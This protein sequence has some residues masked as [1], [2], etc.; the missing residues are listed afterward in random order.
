MYSILNMFPKFTIIYCLVAAIFATAV[1]AEST[2]TMPL[3]ASNETSNPGATKGLITMTVPPEA[4][5]SSSSVDTTT[6]PAEDTEVSKPNLVPKTGTTQNHSTAL[7]PPE[8]TTVGPTVTADHIT[9]ETSTTPAHN[10][11]D[12]P[13]TVTMTTGMTTTHNSSVINIPLEKS[14]TIPISISDTVTK[15]A[16]T[17]EYQNTPGAP[18]PQRNNQATPITTSNPVTLTSITSIATPKSPENNTNTMETDTNKTH[19]PIASPAYEQ[20]TM[21][22]YFT[23]V[24]ATI[25][26]SSVLAHTPLDSPTPPKKYPTTPAVTL[27]PVTLETAPIQNPIPSP[28]SLQNDST[29]PSSTSTPSTTETI[30]QTSDHNP[31]PSTTSPENDSTTPPSTATSFET[32]TS[33]DLNLLP[34]TTSPENDS[35]TPP[36]TA[37]TFE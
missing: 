7:I 4:V 25:D 28:T 14:T 33:S 24:L 20:N 22:F 35:T 32:I 3:S 11:S 23:S 27:V 17:T 37:T 34:F 12:V 2:T 6:E 10:L 8:S 9:T 26:T 29:T 31:L 36:S 13:D 15:T 1:A 5:R 18:T 30:T 16:G 19:N 21:A